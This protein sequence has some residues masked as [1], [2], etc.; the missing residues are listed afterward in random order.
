MP[1]GLSRR[2]GWLALA[3]VFLLTGLAVAGW[4]VFRD[5]EKPPAAASN[6]ATGTP[7]AQPLDSPRAAALS[8]QL[9]SGDEAR[10]RAVLAMPSGQA[11]EPAAA[12]QLASLGS[13]SFDLATFTYLDGRTAQVQG[14]VATPPAAT[15]PRWTFTLLH[16]GDEWKLVDGRPNA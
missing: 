11:L 10:I 1:F 4:T 13:I 6:T 5:S 16:V 15:S 7:S 3:G 2:A 8:E 12:E 14:T 9:T